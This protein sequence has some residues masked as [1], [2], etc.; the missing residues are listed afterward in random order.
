MS[1][2]AGTVSSADEEK[3][4]T[5]YVVTKH[6]WQNKKFYAKRK[7]AEAHAVYMASQGRDSEVVQI[8]SRHEA[9]YQVN[10]KQL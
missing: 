6:D 8:L 2:A 1:E 10:S 3:I 5:F 4:G 7:E 9:V